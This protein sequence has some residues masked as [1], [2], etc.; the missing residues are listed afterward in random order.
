M[1][2][3]LYSGDEW[4]TVGATGGGQHTAWGQTVYGIPKQVL[5]LAAHPTSSLQVLLG[6]LGANLGHYIGWE[7]LPVRL[8]P[9][10][11]MPDARCVP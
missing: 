1:S 9:F 4:H 3:N 8:A 5:P 6:Q 7:A 11:E 10:Q 2:I